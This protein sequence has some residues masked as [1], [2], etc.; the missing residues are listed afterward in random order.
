M[1]PIIY[2]RLHL[3]A[4]TTIEEQ[5]LTVSFFRYALQQ[6][7]REVF[8]VRRPVALGSAFRIYRP[9]PK[10]LDFLRYQILKHTVHIGTQRQP[11]K[12]LSPSSPKL[13][14]WLELL[15]M[16]CTDA[17]MQFGPEIGVQGLVLFSPSASRIN[18]QSLPR[19][20]KN[21][22][23]PQLGFVPGIVSPTF[24]S[25]W[26][27]SDFDGKLKM[28]SSFYKLPEIHSCRP[29]LPIT[30]PN[31]LVPTSW[32]SLPD[33]HSDRTH[34]DPWSSFT[35]DKEALGSRTSV[36]TGAV[37]DI[38]GGRFICVPAL[39]Y[40]KRC[41]SLQDKLYVLWKQSN[42]DWAVTEWLDGD[43]DEDE[44]IRLLR[45]LRLLADMKVTAQ[46]ITISYQAFRTWAL[47][48]PEVSAECFLILPQALLTETAS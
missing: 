14:S 24:R 9:G 26:N 18:S 32:K 43:D 2:S 7:D 40:E 3:S 27:E 42:V 23:M 45:K 37:V 39:Q 11:L 1:G 21:N 44:V 15:A 13:H 20:V 29:L 5:K 41:R 16:L 8:A 6:D 48:P 12:N 36:H 30:L 47:R 28:L 19:M 10:A 22:S 35:S 33:L 31:S 25:M 34:I 38:V 46:D 4:E 17:M